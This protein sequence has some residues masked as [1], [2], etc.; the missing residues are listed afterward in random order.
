MRTT[1][2]ID[3]Q[4]LPFHEL[5]R[6]VCLNFQAAQPAIMA[7]MARRAIDCMHLLYAALMRGV[8]YTCRRDQLVEKKGATPKLDMSPCAR[9]WKSHK[10]FLH[11]RVLVVV[12]PCVRES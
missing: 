1:M 2:L 10:L 11:R 4:Q 8:M 6:G 7:D 3:R 9:T 5:A 12:R